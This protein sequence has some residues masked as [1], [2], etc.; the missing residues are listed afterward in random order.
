MYSLS[1]TSMLSDTPTGAMTVPKLTIK[2]PKMGRGL[3]PGC[4]KILGITLLLIS[5]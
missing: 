3:I 5:L 1:Y 4:L 2:G